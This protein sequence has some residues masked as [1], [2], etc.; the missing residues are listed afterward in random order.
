MSPNVAMSSIVWD[1]TLSPIHGV[2]GLAM[3]P[4]TM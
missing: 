1:S 3:S 2:C 4:T